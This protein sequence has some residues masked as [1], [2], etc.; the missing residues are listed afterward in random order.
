L[1]ANATDAVS[2]ASV[3][4]FVNGQP[5]GG[6]VTG[7]PFVTSWTPTTPGIYTITAR[8]INAGGNQATSAAST[9]VVSNG[10]A[11]T[12]GITSPSSG[13][14]T[15]AGLSVTLSANAFDSDGTVAGVRFFVNGTPVG[16]ALTTAPYTVTWTPSSGGI[17]TVVAQATDNVG[18]I[19]NSSPII[20]NVA[21]NSLPTVAVVSPANGSTVR[22]NAGTVIKATASD[23]DGTIAS[24]QFFVNGVSLGS[25][26]TF[27][28]QTTWTPSAE[29][30]YRLTAVATDNTGAI[31]TSSTVLAIGS[32][33]SGDTVATGS[34]QGVGSAGGIENGNFALISAIGKTAAFIGYS[35]TSGANRAYFY[36][37]IPVS[38][39]GSYSLADGA[40]K[41]LISGLASETGTSGTLDSARL[42]FIG[43]DVITSGSVLTSALYSGTLTGKTSSKVAAILGADGSIIF[44]V[45]DGS[46]EDAGG[47]GFTGK[48]D[49]TGAFN[50]LTMRGNRITGKVDLS[51]RVLTGALSGAD[52]GQFSIAPTSL[53]AAAAKVTG[54]AMQVRSDV[55]H[56]QTHNTYDQILLQGPSATI[57]ADPGQ[58]TR[59]SYVDTSLDIVQVEFSGAGSLSI[60]LDNY[61]G[62]APAANYD[63][64]DVQ[65]VKG[66]AGIVVNGADETTNLSIFSVGRANAVDQSLFK[67]NVKYDGIADLAYVVILTTDG[68]FGG[69]R[70]GDASFFATKGLAGICAPGVQFTGP[71]YV[72]D[73]SAADTANPMLLFSS[74]PDVRVTGGD[75]WQSNGQPLQ[76]GGVS[77][78]K[79]TDGTNSA[80]DLLPAQ[81][82]KARL[83]QNGVDVAGLAVMQPAP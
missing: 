33:T 80:G 50:L 19:T 16:T 6:L 74:A 75:L 2:V 13:F 8:A 21:A 53:S 39:T 56:P 47:G 10:A 30:V 43:P 76:I 66:H 22:V 72:N 59:L 45:L 23:S 57:T 41:N 73:I 83:Q 3:Q 77:E 11:P 58:I 31:T 20:V 38:S 9:V 37:A 60:T 27:P 55:V 25:V 12:V 28:Y 61:S 69:L 81:N 68:K 51:T 71:V 29:G 67:S 40:G 49:G 48:V 36:S 1:R 35:T 42:A 24:V 18:N 46:F 79:F 44:Y 78:L 54:S 65:Y 82:N 26:T 62:P 14:L 70:A 63:Q 5:Q 64:P 34:Y 32:A 15:T 17:Y 4:F 7:F 52:T